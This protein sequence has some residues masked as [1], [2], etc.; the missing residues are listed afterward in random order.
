MHVADKICFKKF[1]GGG[2]GVVATLHF[3]SMKFQAI[4][5]LVAFNTVKIWP[6][7]NN[8]AS[9]K[10]HHKLGNSIIKRICIPHR[11]FANVPNSECDMYGIVNSKA[12]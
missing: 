4:R 8:S 12:E 11:D 7:L 1:F 5:E 2:G 6:E 3:S 9:S 10:L